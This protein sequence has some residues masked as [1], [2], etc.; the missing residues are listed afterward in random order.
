MNGGR[1]TP[2]RGVSRVCRGVALAGTS[3]ALA[4]GAHAL[5]GG[6][7]PDTGLI[8]LLTGAVAGAGIALAD[9]RRSVWAILGVLGAAQLATHVLLSISMV[10]M[11]G[12]DGDALPFNGV[13]M[14]LS[15]AIAVAV[16]AVVLFHADEAV[17][18]AAATFAR[19]VPAIP[20]APLPAPGT[21]PTLRPAV[22]PVHPPS[23][24]LLCR[25]NARRGP[26]VVA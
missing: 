25:A 18:F 3:A 26:P 23:A 24:V 8:L 4:I 21:S 22:V 9:R 12:M 20:F 2:T 1:S 13:T 5:A 19:L 14:L 7:L 15:H 6:G 10:G 16:T 17:F 11:T